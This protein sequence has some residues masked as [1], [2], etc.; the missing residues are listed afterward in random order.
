MANGNID[1]AQVL[2]Q[3]GGSGLQLSPARQS[4][5][6]LARG[7]AS[8][9]VGGGPV[10]GG[11]VEA[12]SR[13]GQAFFARQ[14]LDEAQQ[15]RDER[16]QRL[17]E[18]LQGA[19]EAGRPQPTQIQESGGV[20]AVG[21]QALMRDPQAR[22]PQTENTPQER[23]QAVVN[24]LMDNPDTAPMGAQMAL[25]Q[26]TQEPQEVSQT[27]SGQQANQMFGTQLAPGAAVT[28][29]RSPQGGMSIQD[30]QDPQQGQQQVRTLSEQ[31]KQQFGFPEGSIVQQKPNGEF[32]IKFEPDG[33][34]QDQR[35][36]EIGD[37]AADLEGQV[38]NPRQKATRI[39]DGRARIEVA[40]DG[41]TALFVDEVALASGEENAVQQLQLQQPNVPEQPEVEPADTLFGMVDQA[42]GPTSTIRSFTAQIPFTNVSEEEREAISARRAFELTENELARGLVNNPRFPVRERE[43]VIN[44]LNISPRFLDTK[45]AMQARLGAARDFLQTRLEQARRD[46]QDESLPQETREAQQ[47]NAAAMER[48]LSRIG[49]PAE[50]TA[51]TV[52]QISQLDSESA[53]F[54]VDDMPAP[55]LKTMLQN[56]SESQINQLS[57]DLRSRI[58]QRLLEAQNG[59]R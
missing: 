41:S 12:L 46:A 49:D 7:L 19:V 10:Q 28:V 40:E 1:L 26:A 52:N 39:V 47:S 23:R 15:A 31:E 32:S 58:E 59:N 42:T 13:V 51:S 5:V 14:M 8:Q 45:E 53:S 35:E 43:A 38:P 33:R 55:Q 34:G 25:S 16:R 30:V 50:E 56:A 44:A 27:I 22:V 4:Q 18:T 11:P 29:Q 17:A 9:S 21:A 20:G 54:V 6:E 36:R 37:L 2:Q 48:A 3:R 57:E 24:A